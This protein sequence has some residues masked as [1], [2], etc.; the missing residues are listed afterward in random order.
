MRIK[1]PRNEPR[2]PSQALSMLMKYAP[3]SMRLVRFQKP[4]LALAL[5]V[6]LGL[7]IDTL[8]RTHSPRSHL[9]PALLAAFRPAAAT[10]GGIQSR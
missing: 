5:S 6:P 8:L 9:A 3:W 7:I 2:L 10:P 1:A 4:A